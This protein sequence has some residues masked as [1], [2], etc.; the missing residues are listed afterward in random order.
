MVAGSVLSV[1]VWQPIRRLGHSF[2]PRLAARARQDVTPAESIASNV[3]PALPGTGASNAVRS[4]AIVTS[5]HVRAT[6]TSIPFAL[7]WSHCPRAT[8]GPA[9]EHA[10]ALRIAIGST[11]T[12][13]LYRWARHWNDGSSDTGNSSNE[14]STNTNSSSF[15][16][17]SIATSS[18]AQTRSFWRSNGEPESGYG[19]GNAV[20]RD[21]REARGKPSR[22]INL[23]PFLDSL[24]DG[25]AMLQFAPHRWGRSSAGRA[26]RSQ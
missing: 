24:P 7:A 5:S 1:V 12:R 9:I 13:A 26:S 11:R 8:H 6:L 3:A 21:Q 22:K 10:S 4:R 17:Q 20:G 25:F 2:Q 16:A 15:A 19:I 14:A 18:P 23:S